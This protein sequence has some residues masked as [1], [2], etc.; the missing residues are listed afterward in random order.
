MCAPSRASATAL[1]GPR[2]VRRTA[3]VLTCRP[4]RLRAPSLCFMSAA[5]PV[6]LWDLLV[7]AAALYNAI[8]IP[9]ALAMPAARWSYDGGDTTVAY[10]LDA[11]FVVDILLRFR[12]SFR[13]HGYPVFKPLRVAKK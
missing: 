5:V 6:A 1:S 9:L 3:H 10:I 13:D 4:P 11:A 7:S 12:I 2:H 8:Y